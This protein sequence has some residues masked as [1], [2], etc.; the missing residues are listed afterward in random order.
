MRV[1]LRS[2]VAVILGI[3]SFVQA[4]TL[5]PGA[6]A[7]RVKPS[8]AV[9]YYGAIDLGSKGTKAS[10]YSFVTEEEGKNPVVVFSKTINTKLVSSMNNGAFSSDGISDA[11]SAVRSEVDAMKAEAAKQDLAVD[12]YYVVGS[13]GV[14]KATN[15]QELVAAVKDATG[16]DMDFVSA[17][18]EG[19]YGL[20]SAVP[21]SRRPVSM[22]VD[23]GSG[24]TKLG[25]LVGDAADP[26]SFKSAEI[27]YGSVS[28]RNEALK[29]KPNDLDAGIA[30]VSADVT[31]S[32][33]D[34]SRDVP[35]LRNRQRIYWTGGAAWATATF[36]HPEKEM[37]GW[38]T[39]TKR[40]LDAFQASL[41]N[42]TWNQ[43][44]PVF[45]FPEDMSIEKQNAIRAKAAKEREDVQNVFVRED[46]L[47]GVAIMEA[48]LKSSNP[49][50]SLRFV[51]SGNFIY[52]YALEKFK[53]DNTR[54]GD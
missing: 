44:K 24:N 22:Y 33:G 34:Q 7:K 8:E 11:V 18:D 17:S 32:Y 41:Q 4:Q 15:K 51:R 5:H 35:C 53:E 9:H 31:T 42:G 19:Y 6:A 12:T 47:S 48:V 10:L 39:I 13:S 16:I 25:C 38:V 2:T 30:A 36:T 45:H 27:I 1:M 46:L 40:D 21:L 43:K 14:A 49:D 50:S 37:S 52:G 20:L 23:I 3:A 28:G 29:R 54:A 26:K